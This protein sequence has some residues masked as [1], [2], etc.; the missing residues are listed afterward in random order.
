MRNNQ[1]R[2]SDSS[3]PVRPESLLRHVAALEERVRKLDQALV[4]RA[5]GNVPPK[6]TG[7]IRLE[8]GA[9]VELTS[10]TS[11]KLYDIYGNEIEFGPTGLDLTTSA[12]L[13]ILASTV[14]S[15]VSMNIVNAASSHFAGVVQCDTI[16]A[17]NVVGASYTPDAG[18]IY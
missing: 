17:T 16:I 2:G 4:I 11:I 8:A 6:S 9:G 13:T 10:N 5:N 3:A 1:N 7:G 18:N 12:K 14:K 15:N